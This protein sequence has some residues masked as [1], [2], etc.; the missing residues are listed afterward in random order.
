MPSLSVRIN[1]PTNAMTTIT[2]INLL[3]DIYREVDIYSTSYKRKIEDFQI[4]LH[5]RLLVRPDRGG[6]VTWLQK[7]DG[8]IAR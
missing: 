8:L 2:F 3:I 5:D 1:R 6:V 4:S 7:Q